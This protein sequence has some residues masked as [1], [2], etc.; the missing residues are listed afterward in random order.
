MLLPYNKKVYRKTGE[1]MESKL[2]GLWKKHDRKAEGSVQLEFERYIIDGKPTCVAWAG[3]GGYPK[4]MCGLLKQT[5]EYKCAWCDTKLERDG[6]RVVPDEKC[7]L[8]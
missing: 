2:D 1:M 5:W 4:L 3:T 7:P 6:A 8:W